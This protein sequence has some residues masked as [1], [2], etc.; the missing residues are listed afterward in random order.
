MK[1][2]GEV[3]ADSE[4][5]GNLEECKSAIAEIGNHGQ[6]IDGPMI[7]YLFHDMVS[8][9][10]VPKGCFNEHEFNLAFFNTDDWGAANDNVQP[11]CKKGK[12]I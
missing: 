7:P 8:L 2:A 4:I 6:E 1:P 3:C 9:D 10:H 5:I 12:S 11:I